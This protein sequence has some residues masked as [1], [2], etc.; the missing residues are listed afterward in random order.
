MFGD[1]FLR[2]TEETG[3]NSFLNYGYAII[4]A[5]ISR[6]VVGAGLNP[7]FGIKHY[8]KLNPFCLVDDLMEIYRPIV[9]II[10]YKIFDGI[11]DKNRELD[12]INKEKLINILHTEFYNG[13]GYSKLLTIM[14]NDVWNFVASLKDKKNNFSFN[15][16][17][18]GN[19]NEF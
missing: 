19:K 6:F 4:R 16:Y 14:Q 5:A 18:I 13:S 1:N 10:V 7:S 2:N 11:D 15:K 17:L 8:N 9:D 3:I 12:P